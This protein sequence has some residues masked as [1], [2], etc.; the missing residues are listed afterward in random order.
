MKHFITIAIILCA[1]AQPLTAETVTDKPAQPTADQFEKAILDIMIKYPEIFESKTPPPIPTA[2]TITH[3][4]LEE[5]ENKIINKV[6]SFYGVA[7]TLLLA[8]MSLFTFVLTLILEW[9]R[10]KSFKKEL[11][12][13][14][15]VLQ[16]YTE[17]K[18]AEAVVGLYVNISSKLQIT[19]AALG[20]ITYDMRDINISLLCNFYSACE[21]LNANEYATAELILKSFYEN[22]KCTQG[23]FSKESW[24]DIEN[25]LE[26][27]QKDNDSSECPPE[28][29]ELLKKISRVASYNITLLDKE[30]PDANPDRSPIDP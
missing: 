15:K 10:Q 28:I 5:Y 22:I 9:V 12:K 26:T 3:A 21:A 29:T 24:I 16:T 6:Q 17:D 4:D 2:N 7:L 18:I 1:I 30:T 8:A 19:F 14:E 13:K 11:A 25:D 20:K 27:T 23:I